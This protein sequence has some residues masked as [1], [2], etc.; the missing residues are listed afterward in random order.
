MNGL[1]VHTQIANMSKALLAKVAHMIL[2][3]TMDG[4]QMNIKIVL[5][6]EP[7]VTNQTLVFTD[8]V[9]MNGSTMTQ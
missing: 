7:S 2:F 6:T 4:I 1:D 8:F 9:L 3:S 5:T